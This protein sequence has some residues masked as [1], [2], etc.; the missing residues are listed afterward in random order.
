[1]SNCSPF[2]LLLSGADPRADAQ[3]ARETREQLFSRAS[4]YPI[5]NPSATSPRT[6]ELA[7]ADARCAGESKHAAQM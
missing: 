7:C 1:M 3:C 6:D 5:T 4:R 2:S